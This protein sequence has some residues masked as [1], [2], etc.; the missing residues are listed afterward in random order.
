MGFTEDLEKLLTNSADQGIAKQI[1]Y[2]LGQLE[3]DTSDSYPSDEEDNGGEE[4]EEDISYYAEETDDLTSSNGKT[5]VVAGEELLLSEFL[6]ST[7]EALQQSK[8]ISQQMAISGP[9]EIT[10][11]EEK[12]DR[13][14]TPI[15]GLPENRPVIDS[16]IPSAMRAR[17]KIPRTPIPIDRLEQ[18][19]KANEEF[20]KQATHIH[21]NEHAN[22]KKAA[23]NT[24]EEISSGNKN[25]QPQLNSLSGQSKED[26]PIVHPMI[27]EATRQ[28][29]IRSEAKNRTGEENKK[30]A[31]ELKKD[32]NLHYG[33]LKKKDMD[34]LT[35][36]FFQCLF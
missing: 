16:R 26:E 21:I 15:N 34:Q 20:M 7:E 25:T 22:K 27:S 1:T 18:A 11:P 35:N 28:K 9:E 5:G 10:E 19:K 30:S 3:N 33:S 36:V 32:N 12:K 6:A 14:V 4:S 13:P 31:K 24:P 29:V 2:M 23:R 17:P 8:T